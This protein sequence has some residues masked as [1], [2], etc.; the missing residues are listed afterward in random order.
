[1]GGFRER[2]C[3]PEIIWGGG[4]FLL[5]CSFQCLGSF[6]LFFNV[7]F[8][9]CHRDLHLQKMNC[10]KTPL[11]FLRK[12]KMFFP[13]TLPKLKKGKK[14]AEER[15]LCPFLLLFCSLF[16]SKNYDFEKS[17][18]RKVKKKSLDLLPLVVLYKA[19][20]MYH[21]VLKN[22]KTKKLKKKRFDCVFLFSM[23][24][25]SRSCL[26]F[27]QKNLATRRSSTNV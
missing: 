19:A 13:K 11:S 2:L 27:E 18:R 14:G 1:M 12:Q 4:F 20:G 16:Q 22:K 23:W 17:Q 6:F 26:L 5:V 9:C 7:D 8:E 10:E 25:S 15:F 24:F 3:P 21:I